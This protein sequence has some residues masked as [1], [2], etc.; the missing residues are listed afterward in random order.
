MCLTNLVRMPALA[1][2]ADRKIIEPSM[3]LAKEKKVTSRMMLRIGLNAKQA[4]RKGMA[5]AKAKEKEKEREKENPAETETGKGKEP[6][7]TLGNHLVPT[8][9]KAMAIANGETTVV[10]PT[11]G[12]RGASERQRQWQLKSP[13]KS[14]RSR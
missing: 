9:A 4:K 8:I 2:D 5:M 7:G 12:L 13:K 11:T 3:L 10:S 14:K 6:E 1:S